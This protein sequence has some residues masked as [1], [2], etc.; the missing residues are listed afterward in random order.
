MRCFGGR[1]SWSGTLRECGW[2]FGKAATAK[3][4]SKLR[5]DGRAGSV[6]ERERVR[7]LRQQMSVGMVSRDGGGRVWLA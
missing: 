1:R 5:G 2:S 6:G 4:A 7:G 3:M